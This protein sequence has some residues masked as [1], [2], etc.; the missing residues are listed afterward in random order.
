VF[1]GLVVSFCYNYGSEYSYKHKLLAMAHVASVR[2]H[3]LEH[4]GMERLHSLEH[5]LEHAVDASLPPSAPRWPLFTF[6]FGACACLFLSAMCHTFGCVSARV[7]AWIWKLD[8]V[9]IALLIACSFFPPVFYSFLCNEWARHI[10]LAAITAGCACTLT[11]SLAPRFGGPSWRSVRASIFS[12]LGCSGIVPILHQVVYYCISPHRMPAPLYKALLLELLMGG[13]YLSG[14][15]L[16]A[17][18][19]PERLYPGVFDYAL[20]SHNLFHLLVVAAAL[21]HVEASLVLLAWRDHHA[22]E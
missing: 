22:C 21:V 7:N 8:Y 12:A 9:G 6:L 20:S 10:Y 18:R 13:L 2:L 4:A 11:V 16:Y 5:T 14:A 1:V 17:R 3:S 19:V 15:W